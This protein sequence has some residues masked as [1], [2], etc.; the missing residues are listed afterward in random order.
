MRE[1]QPHYLPVESNRPARTL[2][3]PTSTPMVSRSAI[4]ERYPQ[5]L[6]G[7]YTPTPGSYRGRV[8]NGPGSDGIAGP[9]DIAPTTTRK[10]QS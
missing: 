2:A 5:A 8:K 3:E 7:D 9:V 1:N 6:N 4:T 10:S